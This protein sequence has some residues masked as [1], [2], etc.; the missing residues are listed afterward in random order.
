[1]NAIRSWESLTKI[2]DA[3]SRVVVG[4]RIKYHLPVDVLES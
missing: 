3:D 1:M 2:G 4:K